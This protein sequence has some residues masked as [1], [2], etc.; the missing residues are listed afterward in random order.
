MSFS[1]GLNRYHFRCPQCMAVMSVPV[2]AVA[3]AVFPAIFMIKKVAG[4]KVRIED[5][6]KDQ[7]RSYLVGTEHE[8]STIQGW[9]DQSERDTETD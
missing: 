3:P 4:S 6:G 2:A 5:V 9:T 7:S 1:L 8:L